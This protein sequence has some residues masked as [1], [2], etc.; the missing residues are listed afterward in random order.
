MNLVPLG[1]TRPH[2]GLLHMPQ[3]HTHSEDSHLPCCNCTRDT[4]PGGMVMNSR[5]EDSHSSPHRPRGQKGARNMGGTSA[6]CRAQFL[7]ARLL[8]PGPRR[9]VTCVALEARRP[10]DRAS[11]TKTPSTSYLKASLADN[12]L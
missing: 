5:P 11:K 10:G 6:L 8:S 2:S 12:K 9:T 4:P 1:A 7:T 3:P